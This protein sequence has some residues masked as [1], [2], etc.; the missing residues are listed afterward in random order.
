MI[1]TLTKPCKASQPPKPAS[2]ITKKLPSTLVSGI[3]SKA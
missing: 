2:T 3:N 1:P